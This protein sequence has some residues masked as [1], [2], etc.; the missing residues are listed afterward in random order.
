MLNDCYYHS[1][2]DHVVDDCYVFVVDC[3]GYFLL[4]FLKLKKR[5]IS[6]AVS[7][8]RKHALLIVEKRLSIKKTKKIY[9][10]NEKLK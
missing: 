6:N 10:T 1:Y 8:I 2:Y 5:L 3:L 9:L 7:N 4:V